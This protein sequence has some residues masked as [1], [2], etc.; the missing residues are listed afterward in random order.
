M[1]TSDEV[2]LV[3]KAP[4]YSM[5]EAPVGSGNYEILDGSSK[6]VSEGDFTKAEAEAAIKKLLYR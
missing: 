1:V 6:V 3:V 5:R 4:S 2:P